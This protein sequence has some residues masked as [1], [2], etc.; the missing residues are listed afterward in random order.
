[1]SRDRIVILIDLVQQEAVSDPE[2][3]IGPASRLGTRRGDHA[4]QH[5]LYG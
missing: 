5:G 2:E 1:M 4:F 3:F